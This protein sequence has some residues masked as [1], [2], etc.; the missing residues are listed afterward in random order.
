MKEE[1]AGSSINLTFWLYISSFMI[2]IWMMRRLEYYEA[3]FTL[4]FILIL[5]GL[6][7]GLMARYLILTIK[8]NLLN[9]KNKKGYGYKF[10]V[11]GIGI[12]I[13]IASGIWSNEKFHLSEENRTYKI[14]HIHL[15]NYKGRGS[16]VFIIN[17]KREIE[18]FT[19]GREFVEKIKGQDS[20]ELTL[21]QGYWGFNYLEIPSSQKDNQAQ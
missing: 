6:S 4:L 1:S 17:D 14:D 13:S 16:Y 3:W 11:P 18:R 5:I 15:A 2:G 8:L 9:Q 7:T 12:F 20:V 19:F 10:L 21:F